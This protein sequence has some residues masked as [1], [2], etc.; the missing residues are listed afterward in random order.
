MINISANNT[1]VNMTPT[2]DAVN[3]ETQIFNDIK[4]TGSEKAQLKKV[5]QE[6]ESIFITQMLNMMDKTVDEE[7]GVFGKG[8]Y[9]QNFKSFIYGEMGRE[10]AQN[11]RTTFGFAKQIYEQMEKYTSN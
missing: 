9:M 10:M 5:S 8:K 1:M 4:K 11:P 6:F 3:R 7:G 2:I